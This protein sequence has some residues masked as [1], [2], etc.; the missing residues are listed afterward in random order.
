M[1]IFLALLLVGF[2]FF[3]VNCF[4]DAE[5][6]KITITGIDLNSQ[7]FFMGV[8]RPAASSSCTR[9]DEFKWFISDSGVQEIMTM[10]LTA[11]ALGKSVFVGVS[12]NGKCVVGQATGDYLFITP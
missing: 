7:T 10:A 2:S 4:A 6:F 11:K 5:Q 3:S 8:D 1:K 9:V 12:Q